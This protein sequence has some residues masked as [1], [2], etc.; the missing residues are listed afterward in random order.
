MENQKIKELIKHLEVEINKEIESGNHKKISNNTINDCEKYKIGEQALFVWDDNPN[1]GNLTIT[2]NLTKK[3]TSALSELTE[4]ERKIKELQ[5]QI[6]N[7]KK[8]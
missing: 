7:I 2:I 6:D 3:S 8:S 1:E 4:K 5:A